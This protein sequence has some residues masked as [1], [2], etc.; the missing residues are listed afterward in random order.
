VL[1]QTAEY[2]WAKGGIQTAQVDPALLDSTLPL[3]S[4]LLGMLL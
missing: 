3:S 4:K 2:R 1:V